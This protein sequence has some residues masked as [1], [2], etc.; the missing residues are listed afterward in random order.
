MKPIAVFQHTE[1]GA[2]GTVVPILLS[3][4]HT[5]RVIRIVDGEPVPE[6]ATDFSG[7][8]FMGGYMGVHDDLPWIPRELALI[9]D[10]DARGLP[11]AGHC[12]GSQL[13]ALA[14][15]GSVARHAAPEIGW[16]PLQTGSDALALDW[17]GE[18]A[19]REVQ[20]FQWH[21]DTFQPPPGARQ[22]ARSEYCANQA[23]VLRDRHL[24][25]QSH[26]EMTPALVE[27]SLERNGEQLRRQ[28]AAGNPAVSDPADALSDLELRTA[29]MTTVLTRLY[30]RWVRGCA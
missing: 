2:P 1:V 30:A 25:L 27:L 23:F 7:L 15:G 14:L 6:S 20:T 24:L 11:V 10:A 18:F 16:Q 9:R 29:R 3:L 13:V 8:V 22:I 28:F 26:L 21:G 4:G 19:A 5:V 17:W 12:L